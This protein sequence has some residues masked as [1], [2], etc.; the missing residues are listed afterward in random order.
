[1]AVQPPM[2]RPFDLAGVVLGVDHP[3]A[4]RRDDEMIDMTTGPWQLAMMKKNRTLAESIR[5]V[6]GEPPVRRRTRSPRRS[7]IGDRPR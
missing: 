1:M 2:S 7:W 5:Q 4:G 6:E 3:D